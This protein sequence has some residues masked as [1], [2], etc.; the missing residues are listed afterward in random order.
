[1]NELTAIQNRLKLMHNETACN[2]LKRLNESKKDNELFSL[3]RIRS[4]TEMKESTLLINLKKLV[5]QAFLIRS[6][7]G[8]YELTLEGKNAVNILKELEKHTHLKLIRKYKRPKNVFMPFFL[9]KGIFTAQNLINS[10]LSRASSYRILNELTQLNY[11]EKKI[12]KSWKL[13]QKFKELKNIILQKKELSREILNLISEIRSLVQKKYGKEILII[14]SSIDGL[15]LYPKYDMD[16]KFLEISATASS[17]VNSA[18]NL[19]NVIKLNSLKSKLKIINIDEE[20]FSLIRS[21]VDINLILIIKN[22][23][24]IKKLMDLLPAIDKKMENIRKSII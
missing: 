9:S 14:I 7:R 13:T 22:S 21:Y 16:N 10:N 4:I 5:Q 8:F 12:D 17:E 6:S 2:I 11:L 23:N 24:D 19:N 18:R 20:G 3:D 15:N 1:M